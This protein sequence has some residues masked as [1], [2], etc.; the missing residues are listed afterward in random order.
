MGQVTTATPFYPR[1]MGQGATGEPSVNTGLNTASRLNTASATIALSERA[2]FWLVSGGVLKAGAVVMATGRETVPVVHGYG[3]PQTST[4]QGSLLRVQ[5]RLAC[6][7]FR[8]LASWVG[9]SMLA[10]DVVP[11][12]RQSLLTLKTMSFER[13]CTPGTGS[14]SSTEFHSARQSVACSIVSG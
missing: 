14:R 8:E 2:V 1:W 5:R 12:M 9:W 3:A 10:T 4:R 13:T 7:Q 6:R 11:T